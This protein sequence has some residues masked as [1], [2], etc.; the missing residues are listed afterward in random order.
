M[1][2]TAVSPP[3]NG[4]GGSHSTQRLIISAMASAAVALLVTLVVFYIGY[5]G[6]TVSKSELQN[7][8]NTY[9]PYVLHTATID[10][11]LSRLERQVSQL[12]TDQHARLREEGEE[13]AEL[14]FMQKE[15]DALIKLHR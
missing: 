4:N 14:R 9:S 3:P 1:G 6:N 15:L 10:N 12:E 5:R 13:Q 2:D 11:R 8:I 7:A